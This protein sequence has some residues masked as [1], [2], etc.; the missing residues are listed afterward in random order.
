MFKEQNDKEDCYKLKDL[1]IFAVVWLIGIINFIN[2][3][4]FQFFTV[5]SGSWILWHYLGYFLIASLLF[6]WQDVGLLWIFPTS[7][8]TS[9]I[10]LKIFNF[11]WKKMI[12]R[13]YNLTCKSFHYFHNFDLKRI[14]NKHLLRKITSLFHIHIF[15]LT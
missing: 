8:L 9:P 13:N 4:V 6:T 14:G 2:D 3:L 12:F 15:N 11:F 7:N 1:N 5:S 10:S